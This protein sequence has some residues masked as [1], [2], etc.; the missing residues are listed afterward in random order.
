MFHLIMDPCCNQL[1]S[2]F[3]FA[4]ALISWHPHGI[5]FVE[6]LHNIFP[7]L[8]GRGIFEILNDF[9]KFYAIS[10]FNIYIYIYIN[11]FT[12]QCVCACI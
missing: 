10:I 11:M 7:A 9:Q 5:G 4:R 6:A 8:S 2:R 1:C 12:Y 3:T